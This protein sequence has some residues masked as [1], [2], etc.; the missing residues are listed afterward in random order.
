MCS[1]HIGN[2]P[3]PQGRGCCDQGLD[4]GRLLAYGE[5]GAKPAPS[6][7]ASHN[8]LWNLWKLWKLWIYAF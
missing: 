4:R 6:L 7:I 8:N 3:R 1:G 2:E 5:P